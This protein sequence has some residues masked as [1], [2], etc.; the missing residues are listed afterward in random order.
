[1]ATTASDTPCTMAAK[2]EDE[3]LAK[4]IEMLPDDLM[5]DLR[6]YLD[7]INTTGR[8]ATDQKAG[9]S[10]RPSSPIDRY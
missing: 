4:E 8:I 2:V 10:R 7:G 1:M 3:Y 5:E 9:P 6:E